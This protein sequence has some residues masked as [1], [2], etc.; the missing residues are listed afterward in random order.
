MW[1]LT[2]VRVFDIM[3]VVVCTVSGC[4]SARAIVRTCVCMFELG[5]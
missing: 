3:V 2:V 1:L 5:R 4:V